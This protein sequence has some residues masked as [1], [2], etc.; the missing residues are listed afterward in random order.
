MKTDTLP[1]PWWNSYE[2]GSPIGFGKASVHA[3]KVSDC[4][5]YQYRSGLPSCVSHAP[6]K[7]RQNPFH[8]ENVCRTGTAKSLLN[9]LLLSS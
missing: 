1:F 2:A 6:I 8:L 9:T 5:A 7:E 4:R 3:A